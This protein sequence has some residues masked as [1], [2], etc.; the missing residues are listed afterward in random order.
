MCGPGSE[1]AV[2]MWLQGPTSRRLGHSSASNVLNVLLR[3]PSAQPATI[4]VG[5]AIRA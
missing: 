5:H 2:D 1:V 4:I 3:Y